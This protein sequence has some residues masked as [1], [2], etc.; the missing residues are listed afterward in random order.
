VRFLVSRVLPHR[1]DADVEIIEAF[2]GSGEEHRDREAGR[3]IA[4]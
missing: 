1:R 4:G 2:D 3:L